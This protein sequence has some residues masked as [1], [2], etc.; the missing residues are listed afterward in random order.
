MTDEDFDLDVIYVMT[1]EDGRDSAAIA[2]LSNGRTRFTIYGTRMESDPDDWAYVDMS[3]EVC[4]Q[5]QAALAIAL[6]SVN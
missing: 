4:R 6:G 2:K 5:L 3:D 1:D